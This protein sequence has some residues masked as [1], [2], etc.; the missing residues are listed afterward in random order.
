MAK[1]DRWSD[2]PDVK[3]REMRNAET[4]LGVISERGRRRLPLEDIYRQLFNRDLFLRAYGRI[5]RNDGAMTPGA[6][7]ETVDAMSL[8]KIDAIIG[9]LRQE[10]YRWT[11]VRRTY[12]PKKSGKLRPLGIPTWSDKLLQEVVR[13]L[14]NA[15]YEPQFSPHSHGF[16]PQRGCHT[17][18]GEITKHWRG[19]KWFVEG[20]I[21]QCFDRIDHPVL[22]SILNEKLRDQ[23]FLRLLAN[24]L[25]AG[26][27][28]DWKHHATLSGSPQGGVVSPILSN[29]YLDKLDQFVE[30]ELI[31][32]HNHEERRKPYPPYVAL[33][34]AA[35]RKTDAGQIDE[36]WLSRRQAQQMPSR[37]P[38]DPDFRRLWYVR[39]A[40]DFLLGFSGPREE[41]EQIK[42][43]L[44]GFLRDALKLELS[45]EKTLITHAR[46]EAA[47]FLGYEIVTLDADEK[48]DHRGQ[49]CINGAPGL[50]VPV[51]VIR[52]KCSRYTQRG[53]PNR[54]AARLNDTDF[55]IMTQY[56]AEYRGLVQYYLLAFNV[57]RLWRLHRV[58]E[59]S[60]VK[61]LAGKF[62][63]SVKRIY[64]KYRKTVDVPHGTQRVLEVVVDRGPKKKPLVARFGGIELCWQKHAILNDQ[65]KEVFSVRSEVVQRL[66]AQKCELCGAEGACQVHHVR[67]LADLNRPG[68]G[69]KPP[70]IKRM[71]A[72]RRKSLVVCQRCHEAIH[73]ER[74]KRHRFK[75]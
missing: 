31:P 1:G 20:D 15:Y 25:D 28:E 41:A 43:Q 40:D 18:L 69:E 71:A 37:D 52:A 16:R 33:L 17:A 67:K 2:D 60:L 65:P 75:A 53:K 58:M 57:H 70:W 30:T 29:I 42:Q 62:K 66:L 46:T 55:S 3:V 23:R 51:D 35:R 12:I 54:L 27:L 44:E 61:T 8:E 63:T 59:L 73:R 7:P 36:A 32:A 6:T 14:L 49:R 5:Y 74:P 9:L 21:S 34:N 22:L 56:Q 24:L 45:R 64:R 11:P 47:R 39:Y 13:S 19:V 4:I 68:Q 10:R 72:R 26:Y 48:H 50:K 38:N